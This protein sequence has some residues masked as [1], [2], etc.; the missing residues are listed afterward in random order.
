MTKLLLTVLVVGLAVGTAQALVNNPDDFETYA[1]TDDFEETSIGDGAEWYTGWFNFENVNGV[2]GIWE[3]VDTSPDNATRVFKQSNTSPGA[4]T[5]SHWW[6]RFFG[7]DYQILQYDMILAESEDT[8]N[9]TLVSQN[10]WENNA[11]WEMTGMVMLKKTSTVTEAILYSGGLG[12]LGSEVAL[13]GDSSVTWGVWYTVEMHTDLVANKVK[14]RFG[15]TGGTMN[16]WTEWLGYDPNYENYNSHR[17]LSTGDVYFDNISL[18]L[19]PALL[20]G[21]ANGDGVVSADDYGSV[22]LNFGDTGVAGIPGDA[23]GDGVVS[24]DDYGSVQL[25]FGATAG[26]SGVSVPEPATLML[27]GVG[28]LLLIRRKKL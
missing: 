25:N 13:P 1:L 23:N 20:P 24:A 7:D 11:Y 18:T 27:L 22:Q 4:N 8:Y 9:R 12:G 5:Q 3:I 16:D 2:A 15:P 28:S 26:M 19:P 17:F 6:G 10:K 21:D 14:A